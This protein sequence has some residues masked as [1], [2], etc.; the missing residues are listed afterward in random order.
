MGIKLE[1]SLCVACG[2]VKVNDYNDTIEFL[3][4]GKKVMGLVCRNCSF[5]LLKVG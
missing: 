2:K 5:E 1:D 3:K 4:D